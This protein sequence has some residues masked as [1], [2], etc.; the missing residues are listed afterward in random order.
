MPV[1]EG[2]TKVN[3]IKRDSINNTKV[4][5]ALPPKTL[6]PHSGRNNKSL[7]NQNPNK[8]HVSDFLLDFSLCKQTLTLQ[9][10]WVRN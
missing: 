3:Y 4:R 5:K 7:E 9:T 8:G 10:I 6:T 1:G 2:C